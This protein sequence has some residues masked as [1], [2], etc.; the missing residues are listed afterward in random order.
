MPNTSNRKLNLKKLICSIIV[1]FLGLLALLLATK[2]FWQDRTNTLEISIILLSCLICFIVGH[3]FFKTIHGHLLFGFLLAITLYFTGE[4]NSQFLS[5]DGR[6]RVGWE[7]INSYDSNSAFESGQYRTTRLLLMPVNKTLEL[8]EFNVKER[9]Q[10]LKMVHWLLGSLIVTWIGFLITNYFCEKK[11]I[12]PWMFTAIM[13]LSFT[14]PTNYLALS[15]I[16]YDLFSLMFGTLAIV[17]LFVGINCKL[18]RFFV[19]SVVFSWLAA[20]EK[21]IAIPFLFISTVCYGSCLSLPEFTREFK[22]NIFGKYQWILKPMFVA[23]LTAFFCVFLLDAFIPNEDLLSLE[24]MVSPLNN[25]LIPFMFMLKGGIVL[26]KQ[27][28]LTTMMLPISIL[29]LVPVARQL[30][31]RFYSIQNGDI[32]L[33]TSFLFYIL[34]FAL[35]II[36]TFM[37]PYYW[38][39]YVKI[40]QGFYLPPSFNESSIHFM[41]KSW[42]GHFVSD[43]SLKYSLFFL[44]IPTVFSISIFFVVLSFLSGKHRYVHALGGMM[45]TLLAPLAYAIF[46]LP[47]DKRYFNIFI[48]FY[49]LLGILLVFHLFQKQQRKL[50]IIVVIWI[51][52]IIF[53]LLP[54]IPLIDMK[55]KPV[56]ASAPLELEAIPQ[57]GRIH[58]V[59]NLGWGQ[60]LMMIGK[61]VEKQLKK[62]AYYNDYLLKQ[63]KPKLYYSYLG[64][65]PTSS[66]PYQVDFNLDRAE[67]FNSFSFS[68]NEIY[69]I[70][71][72]NAIR[73]H[74]FPYGVPVLYRYPDEGA[75]TAWAFRGDHLRYAHPAFYPGSQLDKGLLFKGWSMQKENYQII[76]EEAEAWLSHSA[77]EALMISGIGN[78]KNTHLFVKLNEHIIGK[79][80]VEVNKRFQANFVLPQKIGKGPY[81]VTIVLNEVVRSK[82]VR[83]FKPLQIDL[84]QLY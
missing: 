49:V 53:E 65:W 41:A 5:I 78:Q 52:G 26:G 37:I 69:I 25:I 17:L 24:M 73:L 80:V 11:D 3:K 19:L 59:L 21:L 72:G 47:S 8:F 61:K 13:F 12:K 35:G 23:A 50:K 30:Y 67:D 76:E 27:T 38:S 42:S 58:P 84:L 9:I 56:W 81:K 7:V 39:P 40:E 43:L 32:L 70:T 33:K 48:Y 15:V 10:F 63:L 29:V 4:Y 83:N 45:L 44:S 14:L 64:D 75:V 60:E 57:K 55:F 31:N 20:Q 2:F 22:N 79:V 46:S 28:L 51:G 18:E 36:G 68:K 34:F 77:P 74:Q 1:Y 82:K 6:N 54:Y 16:T 71:R 66:L 62:T